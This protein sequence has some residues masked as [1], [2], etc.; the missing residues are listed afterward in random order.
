MDVQAKMIEL[1]EIIRDD[2]SCGCGPCDKDCP[3]AKA[4]ALAGELSENV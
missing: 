1:Y 2:L 4:L 3:H